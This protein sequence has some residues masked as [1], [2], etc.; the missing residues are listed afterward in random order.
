ML[1]AAEA[2][3]RGWGEDKVLLHVYQVREC[4]RRA[5]RCDELGGGARQLHV[6]TRRR[7]SSKHLMPTPTHPPAPILPAPPRRTTS[8]QYSCT[9]LMVTTP[10]PPMRAR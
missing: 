4:E 10:W 2:V 7:S 9:A 5:S 6:H 3:C 1:R 8:Q